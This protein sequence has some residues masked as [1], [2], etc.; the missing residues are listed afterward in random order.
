MANIENFN[1][2][3]KELLKECKDWWRSPAG[4]KAVRKAKT[5]GEQYEE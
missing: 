4:K 1:E 3:Q 2:R 5:A